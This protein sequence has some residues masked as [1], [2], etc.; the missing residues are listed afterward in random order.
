MSQRNS[1]NHRGVSQR[2]FLNHRGVSQ[3]NSS[4]HRGVSVLFEVVMTVLWCIFYVLLWVKGLLYCT[5]GTQRQPKL[6]PLFGSLCGLFQY[7][8]HDPMRTV[9]EFNNLDSRDVSPVHSFLPVF[10]FA[11]LQ[12]GEHMQACF[13]SMCFLFS[14]PQLREWRGGILLVCRVRSNRRKG[15]TG[16]LSSSCFTPLSAAELNM[17]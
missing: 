15:H 6:T 1:L 2:N 7:S 12:W 9:H 8:S 10:L 13:H 14:S 4:N 5:A 16:S 11:S 17:S 3:R